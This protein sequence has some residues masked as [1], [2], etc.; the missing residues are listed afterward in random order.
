LDGVIRDVLSTKKD[1]PTPADIIHAVKG[2]TLPYMS[3]WRALNVQTAAAREEDSTKYQ[4]VIPYL[5]VL[6]QQNPS[7]VIGFSRDD[8]LRLSDVHV[9]PDFMDRALAF[10]RPVIC[11]DA[12]HLSGSEKGTLY[13]A[14]CLSGA[15]EVYP[16]ESCQGKRGSRNLD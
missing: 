3:A 8:D 14:S 2:V 13:V 16:T 9:F 6:K 11:L 12:A 4:L 7:S 10:V 15:N 1:A 5:T